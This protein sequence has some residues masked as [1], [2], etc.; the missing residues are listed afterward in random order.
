MAAAP[1]TG[2]RIVRDIHP[3]LRPLPSGRKP[4]PWKLLEG[5]RA[6]M[7][8]GAVRILRKADNVV[9]CSFGKTEAKAPVQAPKPAEQPRAEK[10]MGEFCKVEGK[11]E[12]SGGW[13]KTLEKVEEAAAGIGGKIL[14]QIE[15]MMLAKTSKGKTCGSIKHRGEIFQLEAWLWTLWYG[16]VKAYQ[17]GGMKT[18]SVDHLWRGPKY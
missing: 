11:K 13:G 16:Y 7:G 6:G 3:G 4:F 14:E 12:K 10:K 1:V 18:K 2:R 15:A 9:F 8:K 17:N 5:G